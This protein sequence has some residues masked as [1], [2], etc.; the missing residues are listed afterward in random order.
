MVLLKRKSNQ[1]K[2][3][4]VAIAG[5]LLKFFFQFLWCI[6]SVFNWR[7]FSQQASGTIPGLMV[8]SGSS[9]GSGSISNSSSSTSIN[10]HLAAPSA[11]STL[12]APSPHQRI[13][14]KTW[15]SLD[16][17]PQRVRPVFRNQRS[18]SMP[19]PKVAIVMNVYSIYTL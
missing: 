13:D 19:T 3:A 11:G 8:H 5:H 16:L 4:A 15:R 2:F 18:S 9:V 17:D 14:P 10:Y 12:A 1:C 6:L 7:L